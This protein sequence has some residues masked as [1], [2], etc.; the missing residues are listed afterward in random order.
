MKKNKK[1]VLNTLRYGLLA[2]CTAIIVLLMP[3]ADHQSY[4]FELNQ[5]WKYPLLTAEFDM[6]VLRDST[7]T[8]IMHDSINA[9]FVPFVKR[10]DRIAAKNEAFLNEALAD[11]LS[12]TDRSL[13]KTLLSRVYSQGILDANL[14]ETVKNSGKK[15]LRFVDPS[16]STMIY[17][18]ELSSVF[19]PGE[20]FEYIDSVYSEIRH[21]K[22]RHNLSPYAARSLYASID[23]NVVLDTVLDEKFRSQE[24]LEVTA[25]VGVIKQGQRIVDR[26]EII[27]TQTFTNL[28]TYLQMLEEMEEED[29]S[30]TYYTIGQTI[31]I[32][33][34]LI[35]LYVFLWHYRRQFFDSVRK[36]T[37][38]MTF[39]TLFEIFAIEMFEYVPNG[40]SMVPFAMVPVVVMIFFDSRT[41][42]IALI[43]TV[44]VCSLVAT[45]PHQFI[46]MEILAGIFATASITQLTRRSQLVQ[47]ALLTFIVYCVVYIGMLLVT[48]GN[49]SMISYR[50]FGY[51]AI[52][53]VILSFAYVLILV[54]EKV[55]GFTSNVTLVELSDINNKLLRRLAEEAPGTFQHSVQVSNLAAEAARAIGA[56]TL[57]V[58]TGAL[59]HDIGKLESPVFFT[60]NQHGVN[61]HNGLDPETSAKKIISHIS[62]GMALAKSN[63]L[64]GVIK[65]F[66]TEHHGRGV[67]KYF[68]ATAV[69][70]RGEENVDK[71]QFQYPGPNPSSKETAI[72]MMADAVEAASRSM[73]DYSP[74]SISNLVN[75]IIDGQLAD[76][77]FKEAPI[78][79]RDIETIKQT[80]IKRLGT[81]YH[82]R[83][84]YPDMKKPVA[85]E[86]KG[87]KA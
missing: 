70:E 51:Y 69:N 40:L 59:Y 23:A 87:E 14:Y 54:M 65:E 24:M 9:N 32:L 13:L 82:T 19:S 35:C 25:A 12:V 34:I 57:L 30:E 58:R 16:D 81:I 20:A 17:T 27:D 26:G 44:L 22:E 68:Y 56:N 1:W 4:S 42:I 38:L 47:T 21:S 83:I 28:N 64:P 45:F 77:M 79:L 7:T 3:R 46:L 10:D 6:P 31:I 36:M 50:M 66:I 61:P 48:E 55:F 84:A 75:K 8:R 71:A 41:A 72:L 73:K 49:L 39:I 53:A 11:S 67:A 29:I 37:F 43:V 15:E 60:E 78:S 86:G 5:P 2:V 52:N 80:F 85:G 18:Q 62:A 33:I 76:G 63:K 74:E